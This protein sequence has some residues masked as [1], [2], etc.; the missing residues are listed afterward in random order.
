MHHLLFNY[1]LNYRTCRNCQCL[2]SHLFMSSEQTPLSTLTHHVL[3]SL[4]RWE[5]ASWI[6]HMLNRN[7]A[8]I[9]ERYAWS[10]TVYSW[11]SNPTR[12]SSNYMIVDVGLPQPDLVICIHTPGWNDEG[13]HLLSL[14]IWNFNRHFGHAMPIHVFGKASMSWFVKH[15]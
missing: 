6:T 3:S 13:F 10:G 12:D 14:L 8:V 11:A 5:F 15:K 7:Y 2:D 1:N 4:H 9:V